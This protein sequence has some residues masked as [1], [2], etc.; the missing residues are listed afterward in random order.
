MN[1]VFMLKSLIG[2]AAAVLASGCASLMGGQTAQVA[3]YSNVTGL[4]V[5]EGL[6]YSAGAVLRQGAV[7]Y[8]CAKT[9]IN[10][11]GAKETL[12][13]VKIDP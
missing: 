12:K 7:A 4:C 2:I 10:A 1:E 5:W 6:V 3:N 9:D 8:E 13:W 11:A